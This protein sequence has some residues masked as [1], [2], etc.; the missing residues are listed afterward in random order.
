VLLRNFVA[1]TSA[2]AFELRIGVP[3]GL[4]ENDVRSIP[5]LTPLI[6]DGS[7]HIA[8]LKGRTLS[9]AA[10][11]FCQQLMDALMGPFGVSRSD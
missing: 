10:A 5:L 11:R 4:M 3:P 1:Q 6:P 7:L 8:Q 2:I 9:V